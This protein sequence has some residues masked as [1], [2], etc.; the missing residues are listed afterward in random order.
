MDLGTPLIPDPIRIHNT[1]YL[2]CL[3]GHDCKLKKTSPT[4]YCDCWEKCKCRALVAGHLG[5]RFELLSRIIAETGGDLTRHAKMMRIEKNDPCIKAKM[6][7]E[8]SKTVLVCTRF[9]VGGFMGNKVSD[10]EDAW[11]LVPLF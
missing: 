5:A 8:M 9:K 1:A 7:T 11:W 10:P 6:P 3:K 4:A 2:L